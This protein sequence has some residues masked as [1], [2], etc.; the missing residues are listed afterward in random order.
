VFLR[1]KDGRLGFSAQGFMPRGVAPMETWISGTVGDFLKTADEP[2]KK[3][4]F[5]VV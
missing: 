4:V 5:N 2:A 3:G 1:Q